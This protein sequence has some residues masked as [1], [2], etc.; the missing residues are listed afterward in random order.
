MAIAGL[1]AR[2]IPVDEAQLQYVVTD[3]EQEARETVKAMGLDLD[4]AQHYLINSFTKANGYAPVML[5][6]DPKWE[7]RRDNARERRGIPLKG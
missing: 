3:V 1:Q 6:A 5:P 7:T 2:D 4:D